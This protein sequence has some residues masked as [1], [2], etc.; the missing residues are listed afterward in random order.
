MPYDQEFARRTRHMSRSAIREIL[1][2]AS[3]PGVISLAGG[4]PAPESFPL[5]L[6]HHL[7]RD[8]IQKYAHRA[9]QYDL[10]EG[11]TPLREAL[12]PHLMQRAIHVAPDQILITSGSQ[13]AL[14]A[15]GK[16]LIS[17]GDLVA[18]ESPTYLGAL[19]AF[20]PYE[21][22]YA[23]I[24]CDGEGVIPEALDEMLMRRPVKFV[25]LVPTFQNPSGRTLSLARRQAIADVLETRDTYLIEDDP[26][27]D[28]RYEGQAVAPIK[29][30]IPDRVIY[31][32]T[33]SKVF[34]PGLRIGYCIA[35]EPVRSWLVLAKQGVDLHTSTFDQALAAEY[36]Q[37]GHLHDH[38]P[39]ILAL[40]RPRQS[41][42]LEALADFM[43]PEFR[44][45][46]PEGGMFVW[47]EGPADI[48][49][50]AVY[51]E[52]IRQQVAYVPGYF[53]F[54]EPGAGLNTMRLNFTMP[55]PE[56]IRSAVRT[57]G[58]LVGAFHNQRFQG[59]IKGSRMAAECVLCW[60]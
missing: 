20:T 17:P 15:L 18:V 41:A 10:T 2:V 23:A 3:Q 34:A 48:N 58:M 28:L 13:G 14:D 5:E 44:W 37:G 19:Q 1:K 25:Y 43:P 51:P 33:L 50:A 35:P 38:L 36:L 16:I 49:L 29:S 57:L 22:R 39:H 9:F 6:M 59:R 11:F 42:M 24:P 56:E 53:F 52:A 4:V 47:V 7:S 54:T 46:R 60:H 27:S 31:V 21:P 32:G 12:A 45:S 30:L 8:V 40:Y 26:Y 55:T